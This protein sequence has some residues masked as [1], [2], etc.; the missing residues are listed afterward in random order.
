[1]LGTSSTLVPSGATSNA[2]KH[3]AP[4]TDEAPRLFSGGSSAGDAR[5]GSEHQ[6][7]TFCRCTAARNLGTETAHACWPDWPG[8]ANAHVSLKT[9]A[10]A[11]RS[12][13]SL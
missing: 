1:M 4:G 5:K 12:G 10:S 6:A 11:A 2:V 3:V 8:C 9:L 7:Q 13:W